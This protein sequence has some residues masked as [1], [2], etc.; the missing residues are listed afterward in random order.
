[1][2]IIQ[3]IHFKIFG[4]CK[5]SNKIDGYYIKCMAHGIQKARLTGCDS[6]ICLKC[7]DDMVLRTNDS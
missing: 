7:V 6:I 3:L 5:I 4:W 1:M 2:N